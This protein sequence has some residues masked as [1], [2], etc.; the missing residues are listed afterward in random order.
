MTKIN[1]TLVYTESN[2]SS[3]IDHVE[4]TN[5]YQLCKS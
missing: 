3:I 1:T 4:E 5:Q 2:V